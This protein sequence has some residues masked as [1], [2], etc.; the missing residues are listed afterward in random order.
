MRPLFTMHDELLSLHR[1]IEEADGEMSDAQEITLSKLE[2]E[3]REKILAVGSWVKNI[4]IEI[5]AKK[6]L[7]KEL[8][9]SIKKADNL[10]TRLKQWIFKAARLTGHLTGNSRDGYAGQPIKSST[11][12]VS[13][14]RSEGLDFDPETASSNQMEIV[15]PHLFHYTIDAPTPEGAK[16]L[17][18]LEA[19]GM[20]AIKKRELSKTMTKEQLKSNPEIGISGVRLVKR[21]NPQIKV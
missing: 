12:S 11:L 5:E 18:A 9:E 13:W 14:R 8:T 10:L 21:I 16:A 3:E 7:K 20:I 2:L 4:Q 1:D 6:S 17:L 15:C 19:S